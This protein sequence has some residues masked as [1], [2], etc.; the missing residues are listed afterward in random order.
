LAQN[1]TTNKKMFDSGVKLLSGTDIPNF[2]LV[3][4]KSLYHEREL[5]AKAGIP[6]NDVV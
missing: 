4:G 3:P 5:L 2:D 1:F 6:N